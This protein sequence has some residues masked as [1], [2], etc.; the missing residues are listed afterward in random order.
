VDRDDRV[1]LPDLPEWE[2]PTFEEI[3]V[4]A[5]VTAYMGALEDWD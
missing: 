3:R 2:P 5:E 1:S 4:S